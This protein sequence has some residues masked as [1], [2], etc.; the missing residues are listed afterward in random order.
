MLAR[1]AALV[2]RLRSTKGSE[3]I[4]F[5]VSMPLLVVIAVGIYDFGTAFTLKHKLNNAVREGARVASAQHHPPDPSVSGSC[6]T[7]SS[8]CT[9]REVIASSLQSSTGND[10]GLGAASGTYDGGVTFSWTFTGS[11]SGSTLKIK[12]AVI[13]P[14][15]VALPNPFDDSDPYIIENTTVTL[16]YPYQWQ[17]SKAFQLLTGNANYLNS[18]ITASSTMQNLD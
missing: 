9:I 16:T 5:A 2:R 7:P 18:S 10:C 8:I 17:F 1:I 4:E 15:S 13:N 14:A 3:I 11:C 12:R 6:G